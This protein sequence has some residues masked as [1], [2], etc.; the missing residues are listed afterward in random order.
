MRLC[1]VAQAVTDAPTL[2]G[3]FLNGDFKPAEGLHL[4]GVTFLR[5]GG[6]AVTMMHDAHRILPSELVVALLAVLERARTGQ[7]R[8]LDLDDLR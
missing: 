5:G 6:L 7:V 1:A 2:T 4:G 8:G 3:R